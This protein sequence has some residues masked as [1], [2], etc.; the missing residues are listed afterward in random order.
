M[1]FLDT[2]TQ[3]CALFLL[4][5]IGYG[6]NKLKYMDVDFNRK[7]SSLILN[8]TAPFLI[9]SSV[10]G[11]VLPKPEDIAPVLTAGL[12]SYALLFVFSFFISK[13]ICK[14][15]NALGSYRFMLIFGNINYI[16]FPVLDVLFG[17]TAIFYA[18]VVTIPFNILIFMFGVPIIT[19]GKGKFSFKW[20]TVFSPCLC[21]TYI[22]ILIV[23]L[24]SKMPKEVSEAC[25][26][27]GSM[28]VP[29]SLLIIG[30]TLAGVPVLKMIGNVRMYLL[31]AIKLLLIPVALFCLYK[32]SPLDYKYTQVL[33]VLFG[34]PVASI[35]TMLC[36][37]NNIDGTTMSEG[38]FLTTLFSVLSI[39]L[40][41]LIL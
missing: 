11:E 29:G 5:I 6:C 14:D 16:G 35:G 41:A 22:T 1:S 2:L 20:L 36:L 9:L 12:L 13:V 21:A 34:M 15:E 18:A 23:I 37:K 33:V 17:P 7:F 4:V 8:I 26:L 25:S 38:T 40:L 19:S 10:M 32:I 27:V 30:S 39:P 3:M 31:T 28:T 24:Q